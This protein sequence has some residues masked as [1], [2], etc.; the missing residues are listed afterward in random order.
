MYLE[1]NND[2]KN[3]IPM[4][5][6]NGMV[7][8]D[9][10]HRATDGGEDLPNDG[11]SNQSESTILKE[12]GSSDYGK[13]NHGFYTHSNH[14]GSNLQSQG[15]QQ[16]LYRKRRREASPSNMSLSSSSSSSSD[17]DD[18][19]QQQQQKQ[20]K[21]QEESSSTSQDR[22]ELGD[23]QSNEQALSFSKRRED[24]K[25]D[26][27]NISK[28]S[29][30]QRQQLSQ[31]QPQ[32]TLPPQQQQ[33]PDGWRV[34]LYRL[35]ADGSWDDCGTGRILCLYKQPPKN[36][37]CNEATTG[38]SWIYQELGEPTLCMH[39]ELHSGGSHQQP[40]PPR[41]LLR[42]RILLRDAY[43]R[44]GDNIITWCE[45]Y[46]EEGNPTQGV[47]LALSFQ[48]NAGCLDIWRQITQVQ[49]RAAD[50]FRRGS[51]G[52]GVHLSSGTGNANDASD[53]MSTNLGN[54]SRSSVVDVAHAVAAAH[55][56]DLQRQQQQEM[57]VNVATEASVQHRLD[58]HPSQHHEQHFEDSVAYHDATQN[59]P[60]LPNPPTLGN[61]EEIADMIAA[62]QVRFLYLESWAIGYSHLPE[63]QLTEL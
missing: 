18:D 60:Q 51:G 7:V 22:V 37:N 58:S 46:L 43:Q 41:I 24:L 53:T 55:H 21:Q 5:T 8:V 42:T 4:S 3:N 44:Q 35:N 17:E 33:Q 12:K 48:D 52:N 28:A 29:H 31:P 6:D 62:V 40:A 36:S 50:L 32:Q 10:M 61:L 57:W 25:P 56:A 59:S 38:D 13:I 19:K 63:T 27:K 26:D 1:E 30:Q 11:E 23:D 54:S 39:S 49:S 20:Q 15:Q 34:K 2:N 16:R 47:D 9:P 45:P 14:G